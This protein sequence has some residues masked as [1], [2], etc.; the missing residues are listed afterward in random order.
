VRDVKI[1]QVDFSG[2]YKKET[3]DVSDNY[4]KNL[5][6]GYLLSLLPETDDDA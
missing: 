6:D 2:D 4:V 5:A 3:A 1:F